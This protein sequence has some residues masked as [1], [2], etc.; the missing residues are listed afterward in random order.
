MSYTI[1]MLT[2]YLSLSIAYRL[3][4]PDGRTPMGVRKVSME[5]TPKPSIN[6]SS[7]FE[8]QHLV[9]AVSVHGNDT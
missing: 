6:R 8:R 9:A 5:M 3:S 4:L 2:Y 1:R 7:V